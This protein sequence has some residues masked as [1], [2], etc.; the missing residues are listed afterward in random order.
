LM[1]WL[2]NNSNKCDTFEDFMTSDCPLDLKIFVIERISR[3]NKQWE[4]HLSN[5][6][7]SSAI[8]QTADS[9]GKF[10]QWENVIS[11]IKNGNSEFTNDSNL[12]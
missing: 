7:V 1:F 4:T 2:V 3:F 9:I 8:P 6:H 12:M 10:Q 11:L 5:V